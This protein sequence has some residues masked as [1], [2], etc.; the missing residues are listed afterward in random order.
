M[1]LLHPSCQP[2]PQN[3]VTGSRSCWGPGD[4]ALSSGSGAAMC[5][6]QGGSALTAGQEFAP[7]R[8]AD[9]VLERGAGEGR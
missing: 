7:E 5:G 2:E 3:R 4:A 1:R 9:E 6:A 8:R